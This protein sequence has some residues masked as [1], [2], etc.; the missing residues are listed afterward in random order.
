[1]PKFRNRLNERYGR[2][3]V[4]SHAG[5]DDRNKHLWDCLCD[6]GE[7]KT[8]VGSNLSSGKSK[9]CGCLRKEYLTKSGNQFG[10]YKNREDAI[11]KVQYSHLKRRHK[12][13]SKSKC[14]KFE[15]FKSLAL[16]KCFYCGLES[17]K[18]LHDRTNETK[19][20]KLLS[21]T[22]VKCN[23]VDRFDSNLGYLEGNVCSCCK[24]CNTAKSTM[25]LS[26]FLAYIKR[27]YNYN[28]GSTGVACKNLD[29][30]FIGIEL[31]QKYYDIAVNRINNSD[32]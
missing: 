4:I 32:N 6:C 24:R 11:L 22:I 25:G 31:E 20:G 10:L 2:L 9:S 1:M 17:S 14:I 21:D 19:K 7:K 13:K 28:Y 3:L 8:V 5:K 16:D 30:K 27:V 12:K 15:T 29:R 23:G 26:E 18:T